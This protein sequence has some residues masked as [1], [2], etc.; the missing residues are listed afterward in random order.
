MTID[1]IK[2]RVAS[3]RKEAQ[4]D[5]YEAA[6]SAENRLHHEVLDAIACGDLDGCT[7]QEAAAAAMTSL[8]ISFARRCA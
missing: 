4:D 2:R 5:D 3:I 7:A 1:G 6:H 8:R